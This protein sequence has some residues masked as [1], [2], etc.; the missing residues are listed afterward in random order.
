MFHINKNKL[1]EKS[2]FM[3]INFCRQLYADETSLFTILKMKS[4]PN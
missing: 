2:F 3:N 4:T 1:K